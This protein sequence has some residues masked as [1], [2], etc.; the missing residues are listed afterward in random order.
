[1]ISTT[2][3]IFSVNFLRHAWSLC[4]Q[5]RVLVWKMLLNIWNIKNP[6]P[7]CEK[8]AW[9]TNSS[10]KA[11]LLM[12]HYTLSIHRDRMPHDIEHKTTVKY[13]FNSSETPISGPCRSYG[14]ILCLCVF[15]GKYNRE[16]SRVACISHSQ[17]F[18]VAHENRLPPTRCQAIFMIKC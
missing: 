18:A 16:I 4:C 10:L 8:S 1:M 9:I 3:V 17:I 15:L 12:Y 6:I 11:I 5:F 13:T 7:V 14:M 2:G